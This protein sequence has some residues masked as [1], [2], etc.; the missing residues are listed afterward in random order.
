MIISSNPLET[1]F[2]VITRHVH[3]IF[4][5]T[6]AGAHRTELYPFSA[7]CGA[8][9]RRRVHAY[10]QPNRGSTFWSYP[11]VDI[12]LTAFILY[13]SDPF[14]A[15]HTSSGCSHLTVNS[16]PRCVEYAARKRWRTPYLFTALGGYTG[17]IHP[18]L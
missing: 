16:I 15:H 14:L 4:H 6:Y 7:L 8:V 5:C 17:T 13:L 10:Y 9:R 11:L 12:L 1:L 3:T 18:S 2:S